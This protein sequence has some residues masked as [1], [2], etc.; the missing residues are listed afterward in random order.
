[1]LGATVAPESSSVA[2]VRG[3]AFDLY[4][5]LA[6]RPR[7]SAPVL[8]VEIDDASLA[9]HG[10]WPWPRTRL[11][12][13]IDAIGE[14]QPAAIG[15]D[16]VMPE[17]DRL[18]PDQL[19]ALLSAR[20]AELA[21]R[22]ARLPTNDAVLGAAI[23]RHRAVLG[24]VGIDAGDSG[25]AILPRTTPVR[26]VGEDAVR[27]VQAFG[28]ALLSVDPIDGGAAG[29][30]LVNSEPGARIVRRLPVVA[31]V[32]ETLVPSLGVEMLRV[33]ARVPAFTVRTDG[34]VRA[35]G[36]G[37]LSVPTQPDGTA[38]IHYGRP[39]SLRYV[40]AADVLSGR[41][42][43]RRSERRLVLV[44]VT[45]IGLG[46]IHATPLA[47]RMPGVEIHAQWLESVFDGRFLVRPS[48]APWIEAGMLA[49][50]AAILLAV[51]PALP[52]WGAALLTPILLAVVAGSAF[53][54]YLGAGLLIDA[55]MP[56]IGL[57]LVA[58]TLVVAML[59]EAQRQR[60][61]L[62][63]EVQAQREAAAKVAG[64]LEAA[65]RIQMGILPTRLVGEDRV[66]VYA[67]LQPARVVGGDLYDFF[68]LDADRLFF[69]I[70]DVAG[71]GVAGS[72]F[73]AVSKALCKSAALRRRDEL[74]AIIRDADGEI[75]RDNPEA[76][77]VSAW[78]GVLDLRSGALQHCNAGH[79][80]AWLLGPGADPPRLLK[81]EGGPPLCVIDGFPYEAASYRMRPGETICL[82]TDGVT[83]AADVAGTLY[84]RAR[85][86]DL[87]QRVRAADG[88]T[89]VGE[90]IRNDLARFTAGAAASDDV[91][92]LVIRWR[93]SEAGAES[94]RGGGVS[95]P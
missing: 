39:D 79:E 10:Q 20:D 52:A 66:G 46:D 1:M 55:A 27:Y 83:E 89:A 41:A 80:P 5:R 17:P 82:V 63:Q 70:A 88:P 64:E 16:I 24:I 32:G 93:G 92:I 38:F 90:A 50:G 48:R 73:M 78:A 7:V 25:T 2:A 8:I 57:A 75:A 40:S 65:R 31:R 84:G 36:I 95:E 71:K 69:M 26:V 12:R 58:A 61:A 45:A 67:F 14:G 3:S 35:V 74:G 91:T 21:A 37:D 87:L 94:G 56:A 23:A 19:G 29:R 49:A 81:E 54:V 76:L 18:S 22:L 6:P 4:Q 44:G 34:G 11:A 85:L 30:G 77:F 15:I 53:A 33:A 47:T 62:R 68:R 51:L 43:L 42:D 13:L 59:A 86:A 28:G 60:R 72:L 9:E